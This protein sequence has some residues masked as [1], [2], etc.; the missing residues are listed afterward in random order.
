MKIFFLFIVL[1]L[2][3]IINAQNKLF[4]YSNQKDSDSLFLKYISQL[5]YF[6]ENSSLNSYHIS[7][8]DLDYI[9]IIDLYNT[10]VGKRLPELVIH[11]KFKL[12]DSLTIDS[13]SYEFLANPIHFTFNMDNGLF[14][15]VHFEQEGTEAHI[16]LTEYKNAEKNGIYI[17]YYSKVY[18]NKDSFVLEK[19]YFKDDYPT[20]KYYSY[21]KNGK[22]KEEGDSTYVFNKHLEEMEWTDLKG[23]VI[24]KTFIKAYDTSQK[25][26]WRKYDDKGNLIKEEFN[27]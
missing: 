26:Y 16:N 7:D 9:K 10:T 24:N 15:N 6:A 2:S 1:V 20:G 5:H 11:P 22:I 12:K 4:K 21:Y 17:H 18:S 27:K 13:I 14:L 3:N 19:K 23:N 8:D 25:G